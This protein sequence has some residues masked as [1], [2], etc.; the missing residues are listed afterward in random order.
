VLLKELTDAH[1][2]W[3]QQTADFGPHGRRP[4]AF[5]SVLACDPDAV[6]ALTRRMDAAGATF[7]LL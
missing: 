2:L 4:A 5:Q 7:T 1:A 3:H 6:D